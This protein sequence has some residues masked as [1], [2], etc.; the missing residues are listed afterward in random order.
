MKY[1]C[2]Y[3]LTL[4]TVKNFCDVKKNQ[5]EMNMQITSVLKSVTG[6]KFSP[7][8]FAFTSNVL[9]TDNKKGIF[10]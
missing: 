2:S 3:L 1:K 6:N 8:R 10:R 5:R 7:G 4:N 9:N